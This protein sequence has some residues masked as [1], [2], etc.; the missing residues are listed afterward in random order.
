MRG[1][2]SL[3]THSIAEFSA[4]ARV[5]QP[6]R[7]GLRVLMYHS[8]GSQAVGDTL[9]LY[10]IAPDLFEKH[11]STLASGAAGHPVT[12]AGV[13]AAAAPPCIA[14]TFDDGYRD[15]LRVAAP[16]LQKHKIPFTVFVCTGFMRNGS[17]NFLAPAEVRELASM[18]G[19]TIG[20]HG[21]THAALTG[22]DDRTLHDELVTS[23]S[24]LENIIGR[25]VDAISYPHGAVDRRV[26]EAAA[27]AGYTIGACSRFDINRPGR[28]QL[29]LC[30]TDIHAGDTVRVFKQK[31]HGDW[32][33]YKWRSR[34][35]A[36]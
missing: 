10:G 28:D 18:T 36:D 14:V 20:S 29:L 32:D 2:R 8:V 15:N 11:M 5:G 33:W 26:R 12:L 4:L 7:P 30:R 17:G 13:T 16:V 9:G 25:A 3:I 6:P 21:A 1:L 31:L 23:K 22:L 34:D 27:A 24:E 35:P 19:V